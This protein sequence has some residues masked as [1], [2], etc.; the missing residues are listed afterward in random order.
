MKD[1]SDS[2]NNGFN[3]DDSI[4]AM[5]DCYIIYNLEFIDFYY[6]NELKNSLENA[7]FVLGIQSFVTEDDR[8]LYDVILPLATVFRKSRN[9]Y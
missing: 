7:E 4:K 8:N 9:I 1:I 5:L 6:N 2:K 3:V